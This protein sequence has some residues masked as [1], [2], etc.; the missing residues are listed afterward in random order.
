LG[1]EKAGTSRNKR[2]RQAGPGLGI[3][4]GSKAPQSSA[5]AP[6]LLGDDAAIPAPKQMLPKLQTGTHC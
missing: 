4:A 6:L 3:P 2:Q 1:S 5:L